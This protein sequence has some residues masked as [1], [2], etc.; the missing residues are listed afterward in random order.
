MEHQPPGTSHMIK[1][2]PNESPQMSGQATFQSS[3]N[4]GQYSYG[5]PSVVRN[6]PVGSSPDAPF[7]SS[8]NGG[9]Y[10]YGSPSVVRNHPVGSLPNGGQYS[11]G[12]PSVVRHHPVGSSQMAGQQQGEDNQQQ[13]TA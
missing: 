7:Q 10:S 11:N 4:G 5:S 9:Q 8:Q 3:Q 2:H 13:V 1:C 12:S 6:H